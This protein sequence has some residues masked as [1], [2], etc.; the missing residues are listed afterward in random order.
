MGNGKLTRTIYKENPTNNNL[1]ES[2]EG[3]GHGYSSWL[4][5]LFSC[6]S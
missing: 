6:T 1:S 2:K 4:A 3:G 5:L